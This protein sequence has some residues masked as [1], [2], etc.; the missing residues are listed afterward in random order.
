MVL[1]CRKICL[2]DE[3][4][5]LIITNMVGIICWRNTSQRTGKIIEFKNSPP[6]LLHNKKLNLFARWYFWKRWI[7]ILIRNEM[8]FKK[9]YKKLAWCLFPLAKLWNLCF[10]LDSECRFKN[11]LQRGKDLNN[12]YRRNGNRLNNYAKDKTLKG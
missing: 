5:S 11:I 10:K 8:S 3:W 6:K 2:I 12:R 1:S 4:V 7:N 9:R